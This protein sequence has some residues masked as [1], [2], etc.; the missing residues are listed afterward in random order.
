MQRFFS[1]FLEKKTFRVKLQEAQL[2]LW[3]W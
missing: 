3:M 1:I 2:L